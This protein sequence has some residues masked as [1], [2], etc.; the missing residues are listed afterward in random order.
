MQ[1]CKDSNHSIDN[2]VHIFNERLP[3]EYNLNIHMAVNLQYTDIWFQFSPLKT[4]V[5][6][7]NVCSQLV[8][9]PHEERCSFFRRRQYEVFYI[10]RNLFNLIHHFINMFYYQKLLFSSF[11]KLR[12]G[13]SCLP[14]YCILICLK[15]LKQ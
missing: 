8:R 14:F 5:E 10:M 15:T 6:D 9:K 3:S 13:S 11:F 12:T 7:R 4:M 2:Q 1:L